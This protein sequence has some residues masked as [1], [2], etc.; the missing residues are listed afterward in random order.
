MAKRVIALGFFDGVHLGHRALLTRVLG[1]AEELGAVPAVL[2]FDTQPG[3]VISGVQVPLINSLTD[4]IGLIEQL[5]GIRDVVVLPFDE[6]IRAMPWM[7]FVQALRRDYGAIHLVCGHDYR[8]G[9]RGEGNPQLLAGAC[10]DL[11]MGFDVMEEVHL[12][13]VTV[14]ST[15]IRSLLSAGEIAGANRFLGHPHSFTDVVRHGRKLGR[16]IGAPTTNMVIPPGVIVPPWGVYATRVFTPEPHIAVTNVGIRPTVD[17][18]SDVTVES[19]ILDFDGDLYERQIR[20]EFYHY[21]RPEIKF[22]SVE[23]LKAQIQED[24]RGAQRFFG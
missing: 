3:G 5:Y 2:T 1:R 17:A 14:S 11:G 23:A 18:G 15:H 22:D 7:D 13:G 21:L 19:Y 10:S 24:V 16:T 9:Y 8:F 4:R 20:V 6:A 12:D